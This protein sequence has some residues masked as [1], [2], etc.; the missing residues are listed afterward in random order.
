M[1]TNVANYSA[2]DSAPNPNQWVDMMVDLPSLAPELDYI[3]ST[4]QGWLA[5]RKP[6]SVLDAGCGP[7]V[8]TKELARS[9]VSIDKIIGMDASDRMLSYARDHNAMTNIEFQKGNIMELP[10]EANTFDA[11]RFER[12]L[13]HVERPQKALSEIT[14]VLKPGGYIVGAESD[15]YQVRV[16]PLSELQNMAFNNAFNQGFRSEAVGRYLHEYAAKSG[17][18]VLEHMCFSM[19]FHDLETIDSKFEIRRLIGE[20]LPDNESKTMIAELDKAQEEHN[21][22][23]SIPVYIILATKQ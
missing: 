19:I 9:Q 7:G 23:F 2:V 1:I 21:F 22:F 18:M 5:R 20:S 8:T 4:M 13:H 16:H 17:L 11:V 12:V 6:K 3:R 14:R 15:T 10:F